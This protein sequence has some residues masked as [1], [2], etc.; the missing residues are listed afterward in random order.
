MAERI[1]KT[2]E[3]FDQPTGSALFLRLDEVGAAMAMCTFDGELLGV[4]PAAAELLGRA[5]VR[6][7][8][9]PTALPA[10]LWKEVVATPRGQSNHW[11][12]PLA[13]D[14]CLG[15]SRYRLGDSAILLLMREITGVH[16]ERSRRFQQ[17][18]LEV[19]GRLV[20]GITHDL[21]APLASIVFSSTV[22][23]QRCDEL[24]KAELREGLTQI[25]EAAG[26]LHKTIAGLLEYARLGPPLKVKVS[27]SQTFSRVAG[28][29]RPALREQGHQLNSDV[30]DDS[31]LVSVNQLVLEQ[32]IVNLVMNAVEAASERRSI[33]IRAVRSKDDTMVEVHVVDDGPGISSAVA[34]RVF[35]P[36][37]TTKSRGTGLGLTT[38]REAAQELGGNLE[39][40]PSATGA[41]FMLRLPRTTGARRR[42]QPK[43]QWPPSGAK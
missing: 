34:Q 37:F 9:L 31:D 8:E 15:W 13:L 22:L 25:K 36:F 2:E 39:L 32:I 43:S 19:I 6:V 35:E 24:P 33:D 11:R 28:L 30:S 18:R 29:L 41:H 20:A 5:G 23:A 21:R 17:Q 16:Q 4:S 1:A 27:L 7:G 12:P 40:L 10:A 42:L 14:V 38:S 26:Q 3:A